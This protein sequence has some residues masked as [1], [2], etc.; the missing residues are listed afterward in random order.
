MQHY[1][2]PTRLLDWTASPF[3]ALYFAVVS[4]PDT[5]GAVWLIHPATVEQ[6]YKQAT[7]APIPFDDEVQQEQFFD[8]PRPLLMCLQTFRPTDRMSA[9][10]TRFTLATSS[11][12]DHVDLI[13]AG[14]PSTLKARCFVKLVIPPNDKPSYLRHLRRMNVT[15]RALF[16]GADGLGRSIA[17]AI[18]L[19]VSSG[20]PHGATPS[21]PPA[22]TTSMPP[23]VPKVK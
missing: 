15:A 14:V 20:P 12:A 23:G 22:G 10:Q 17:E 8:D 1:G 4:H 16:P 19:E 21:P 9:Q 3:V 7:G 5:P 11:L 18:K 6:H 13:G 2:A